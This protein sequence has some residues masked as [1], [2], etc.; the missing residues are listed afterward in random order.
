MIEFYANRPFLYAITDNDTH[1]LLFLGEYRGEQD[2]PAMNATIYKEGE[3]K[4]LA[5]QRQS[6][7]VERNKRDTETVDPQKCYDIVDVMPEFPY[8]QEGLM[9]FIQRNIN[10]PAKARRDSLQGRVIV[11][12]IV[13][14]D[15][16]LSNFNIVR[17]LSPELNAEALR[18]C[19]LMP[20]WKPG[21]MNYQAVRVKYTIP[22]IFKL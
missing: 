21:R 1:A 11:T 7:W 16:S 15:G 22:V 3:R 5:E 10:Y 2:A 20:K 14:T 12:F 17:P 9:N 19:R 4:W 8:G 6:E 13:E 18:V